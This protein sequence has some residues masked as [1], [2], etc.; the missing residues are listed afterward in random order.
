MAAACGPKAPMPTVVEVPAAPRHPDG[1]VLELPAA[2]PLATDSAPARGV[3]A[4]REPL[5]DEALNDVVRDYLRAWIAENRAEIEQM[6]T[7]DCASLDAVRQSR[8]SL[9]ET[10]KG[11]M[12]NLDY[13]RLAG[14]EI[15]RLDRIERADY[16]GL[17]LPGAPPRPPEMRRGDLLVRVPIATP[18][19][20]S[21]QLFPEVLVLLLRREEGRYRIAGIGE[22]NGP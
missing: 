6:L 17:G 2:L 21:E 14:V 10:F 1:V 5:A 18:R 15:A 12:N 11:R 4:L 13:K 22:E 3:V 20:G 19:I 8:S 7:L 9:L 16:A